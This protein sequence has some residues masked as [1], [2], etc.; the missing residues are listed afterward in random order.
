MTRPNHKEWTINHEGIE[1]R[2]TS[3]F[4]WA[5]QFSA[6]LFIGGRLLD[7]LAIDQSASNDIKNILDLVDPDTPILR[8]KNVSE[9]ISNL[10]V[11]SGGA[12]KRKISIMVDHENVY[13]DKLSF[14]DLWAAKT[15]RF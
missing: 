9:G 1:I 11:Y 8:A 3:W 12:F 15:I 10:E 7:T 14:F 13:R 5:G 2:V 4:M 6:K